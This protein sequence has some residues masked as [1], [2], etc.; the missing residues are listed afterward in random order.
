MLDDVKPS[1]IEDWY[2][3]NDELSADDEISQL[4]N[5]WKLEIQN[6]SRIVAALRELR[7]RRIEKK[8]YDAA[9]NRFIV[10]EHFVYRNE[11]VREEFFDFEEFYRYLMGDLENADLFDYDFSGVDISNL[12][13][14]K[15]NISSEAL[16]SQNRYNDALKLFSL[17]PSC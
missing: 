13:I 2:D 7:Y 1:E 10:E 4:V 3:Y 8:Y 16:I 9:S 5:R 12:D 6:D 17:D 14:K 11:V 15:A